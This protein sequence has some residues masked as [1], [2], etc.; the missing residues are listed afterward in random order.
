MPWLLILIMK[1]QKVVLGI[2]QVNVSKIISIPTVITIGY[3]TGLVPYLSGAYARND[4]DA[5]KKHILEIIDSINFI[6]FLFVFYSSFCESY[7]LCFF[8]FYPFR[9]LGYHY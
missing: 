2:Y 7:L 1:P 3:S 4:F 9:F 6:I 8:W 5:I